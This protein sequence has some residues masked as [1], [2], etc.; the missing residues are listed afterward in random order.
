MEVAVAMREELQ[1]LLVLRA[2]EAAGEVNSTSCRPRPKVELILA[3]TLALAAGVESVCLVKKIVAVP[4]VRPPMPWA[5]PSSS[6]GE[7]GRPGRQGLAYSTVAEVEP[8]LLIVQ[9]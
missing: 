4:E 5:R 9:I 2:G 7:M 1:D 8:S 3:T 6:Q